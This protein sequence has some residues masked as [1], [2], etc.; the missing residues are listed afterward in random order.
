MPLFRIYVVT[1]VLLV[2][3]AG[4][5]ASAAA[6]VPSAPPPNPPRPAVCE[7]PTSSDLTAP[8]GWLNR[9]ASRPGT[10]GVLVD[11]GRGRVVSHQATTPFP[12]A[13][14]SK[15]V[16]LTAYARAV[17]DERVRP[18][19]PV[20]RADW[21]RWYVPGTDAGAHPAAV[22][23][24]GN[25]PTVTVD[26]VVSAMIRE[27]DNSSA[28]WL[29][30]RLGDGALRAAAASAG[31]TGVD[32]PSYAGAV[33]RFAFP[34][35]APAGAGR[36][37]LA[38]VD[39]RLG[40]QV[41]DDPAFRTD[42]ERRYVDASRRDPQR[43]IADQLRW[44]GTTAAATPAHVLGVFR[45]IATG[46]VPGADL[47]RRQLTY[48]GPQPQLGTVGFK[49]GSLAGVLTFGSFLQREDGSIG[50]SVVLGRDLPISPP[51]SEQALGQQ[52]MALGVLRST[53]GFD[54]LVCVA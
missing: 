53:A 1:A 25:R 17:S 23:R 12:L 31:W 47:A 22:A 20:S 24:L 28:D 5:T 40:R 14:L 15:V 3:L 26:E 18:D 45:A 37:E 50:Y 46:T 30:A 29:R 6:P 4:C 8:S 19:E 7:P 49:G 48:Q 2:G 51:T 35:R 44:S 36:A 38:T 43:F 11:D 54:R 13:S 10:V 27:S 16:H 42:V 34:D 21:E 39:A 41:A 9:V 33:A 52:A 32:L